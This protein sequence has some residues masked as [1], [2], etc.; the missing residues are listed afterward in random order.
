MRTLVVD[1]NPVMNEVLKLNMASWGYDVDSAEDGMEAA[2]K[3]REKHY[4]IVITDGYMPRMTGFDLCRFIRSMFTETLIIGVTGSR[5]LQG[6]KD[7]GADACFSKPFKF[8][9]LKQAIEDHYAM[10]MAAAAG[11]K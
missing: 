10:P 1:D 4:D 6:F 2:A 5:N 9:S 7:A 3:L 8:T 11:A